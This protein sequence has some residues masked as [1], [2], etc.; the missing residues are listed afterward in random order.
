ME[1]FEKYDQLLRSKDY[2]MLTGEEKAIVAHFGG[3]E[4]YDRMRNS[5]VQLAGEQ[6]AVDPKVRQELINLVRTKVKRTLVSQFLGVRTPGYTHFITA[7]VIFV[8]TMYLLPTERIEIPVERIVEVRHIDTV[9]VAHVDTV[10][11]EREVRVQ[12][13]VFVASESPEAGRKQ[14]M[15]N[16]PNR[17]FAESEVLLDLVVRSGD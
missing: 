7:A 3:K 5:I 16:L 14:P 13:P 17:S 8:L 6:R 12:V 11:L 1:N 2:K 15:P 9:T 10:F 4:E